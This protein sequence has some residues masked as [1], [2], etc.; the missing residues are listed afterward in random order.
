M[1]KYFLYVLIG[2]L[3]LALPAWTQQPPQS[4]L[5]EELRAE[6][7]T[8]KAQIVRTEALLQPLEKEQTT[9]EAL[10]QAGNS[11]PES[12]PVKQAPGLNTPPMLPP[13]GAEAFRKTPPRFDVLVQARGDYLADTAKDD[14]FFL[15]KAELGVKGHISE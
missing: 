11:P 8:L 10:Q 9:I 4:T 15:R 5:V 6:L 12:A 13:S 2:V 3:L 14:T 7:A 1:R